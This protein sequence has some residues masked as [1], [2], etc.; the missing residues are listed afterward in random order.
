MFVVL[1]TYT[2]DLAEVD[3]HLPA[4]VEYL[5]AQYENGALLM[6]GRRVPRVGGVLLMAC[7]GQDELWQAL[8]Q[9]PFYVNGV[10]DYQV[11]RF[12]PSMAREDLA[13]LKES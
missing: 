3:R 12:T 10:A 8:R 11:L 7:A 5:K 9:D 6:S 4:H 1:V 13:F 2:A